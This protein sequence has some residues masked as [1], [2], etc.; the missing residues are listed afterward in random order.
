[1]N[2]H[3]D[4][5]LTFSSAANV[6]MQAWIVDGS[7]PTYLYQ[8]RSRVAQPASGETVTTVQILDTYVQIS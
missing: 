6:S 4:I 3:W 5:D 8:A 1:M 2:V 7:H